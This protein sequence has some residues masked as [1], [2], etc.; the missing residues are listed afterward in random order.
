MTGNQW[1]HWSWKLLMRQDNDKKRGLGLHHMQDL[2][3]LWWG[4]GRNCFEA[5]YLNVLTLTDMSWSY[6]CAK[7]IH[8]WSYIYVSNVC[9]MHSCCNAIPGAIVSPVIS[10]P[11]G[12]PPCWQPW[13]KPKNMLEKV[14]Q[15]KFFW[16]RWEE[17]FL[18]IPWNLGFA[19]FAGTNNRFSWKF[20]MVRYGQ[21]WSCLYSTLCCPWWFCMESMTVTLVMTK[22]RNR[23]MCPS[24]FLWT[25]GRISPVGDELLSSNRWFNLKEAKIDPQTK[26]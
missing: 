8:I 11:L 7:Y 17:V 6:T 10:E 21:T 26:R 22:P 20:K 25:P 14:A 23:G 24:Q 5:V 16:H 9:S 3:I 2:S 13:S 1:P 4:W 15:K 18:A 19:S 12:R